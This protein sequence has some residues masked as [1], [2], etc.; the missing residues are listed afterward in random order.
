MDGLGHRLTLTFDCF[1]RGFLFMGAIS[2]FLQG[3]KGRFHH[4]ALGIERKPRNQAGFRDVASGKSSCLRL[5]L[6]VRDWFVGF[7]RVNVAQSIGRGKS[8]RA[9]ARGWLFGACSRPCC[10]NAVRTLAKGLGNPVRTNRSKNANVD[11][12]CFCCGP[13]L[14]PPNNQGS[15]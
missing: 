14:A 9:C 5:H 10:A 4:S 8:L 1:K 15:T 13:R 2:W 3:P 7:A 6:S 12:G 11:P